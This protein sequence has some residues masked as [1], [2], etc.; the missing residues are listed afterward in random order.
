MIDD[1]IDVIESMEDA[2]EKRY[3]EMY[4]DEDHYRCGCGDIVS[5]K[6]M[7]FVSP[8]PY[9]TPCCDKCFDDC[10]GILTDV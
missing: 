7:N 6:C 10:F 8:N 2:A 9:C 3:D 5:N 4:V 1:M